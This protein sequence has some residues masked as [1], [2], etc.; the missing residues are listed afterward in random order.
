MAVTV[1]NGGAANSNN[2]AVAL[3]ACGS[4][5][6][7]NTGRVV[8]AVVLG[9]ITKSVGSITHN[10]TTETFSFVAAVNGT[11]VRVEYWR[12]DNPATKTGFIITANLAS[13]TCAM[14]IA[15]QQYTGDTAL[16]TRDTDVKATRYFP[17]AYQ[18]MAKSTDYTLALVGFAG[19]AGDTITASVG[20]LRRSSIGA[21]GGVGV[22][23]V[24]S[25]Q[26]AVV[27]LLNEVKLNNRREFVAMPLGLQATSTNYPVEG[28]DG[29]KPG[30]LGLNVILM[31]GKFPIGGGGGILP[32]SGGGQIFPPPSLSQGA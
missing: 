31:S 12:C 14:A 29:P 21:S 1:N 2:A 15:A 25:T 22:A 18:T 27:K 20:T 32:P 7:V 28:Y 9:D 30:D 16:L 11:N 3:L 10:G 13:G 24:D 17:S 23:I 5:N 26:A 4:F 19:G 6:E 8:V